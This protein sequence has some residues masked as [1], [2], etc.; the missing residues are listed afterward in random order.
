MKNQKPINKEGAI[1]SKSLRK[2]TGRFSVDLAT[3]RLLAI[4][5]REILIL[6]RVLRHITAMD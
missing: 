2:R 6:Q 5:K 3:K 4:T 1:A